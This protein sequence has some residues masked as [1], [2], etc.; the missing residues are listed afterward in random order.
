ML[1]LATL[2]RNVGEPASDSRYD[3]PKEL[4]ALGYTG[5][6]FYE[7][8]A[9]SGVPRPDVLTDAEL[10]RWVEQ[11]QQDLDQN[12]GAAVAA[13][14]DV[15]L[16]YDVLALAQELVQR[17]AAV[18]T[19]KGRPDTL[20]PASDR[21][22]SQ[23]MDGL[24]A[25]LA[26]WPQAAGVVLR[27]GDTDAR[28]LPYL[29]GNDLYA[30]HCPRCNAFG[31]ADRI[32]RVI[33]A[34]Y[35][36]VVEQAGKRLI[37]RAWNVR[38]GGMHD[39][40]ELTQRIVERLP[41]PPAS[42]DDDR[43]VL[44]FKFTQTDFWRYQPW[45]P[46]SLVCGDR[47]VIYE[48][49]C[50]REFEGKGGLPSWQAGLWRDGCPE[51]READGSVSGLAEAA[52]RMN[53]AGVMAWVR[54]G[55]WGGP[56]VSDESWIDA[57]VF[58]APRLADD[59]TVSPESLAEGWARQRL[60]LR[61]DNEVAAVCGVLE[62][63][64]D[65]V[66]R[67]F[68]VES[69]ARARPDA[70][71]PA[72]DWITDDLLDVEAAWRMVQGLPVDRLDA[73]VDEKRRAADLA[74]ATRHDFQVAVGERGGVCETLLNTL[75]YQES[76]AEA[77]RDLMAG[78]IAYRRLQ[79]DRKAS[80]TAQR[81]AADL[82]RRCLLQA[83]SHWNHH[84]QRHGNLRGTATPFRELGLWELTQQMMAEASDPA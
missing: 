40:P 67:A 9:M 79:A 45:N 34:A 23:C 42:P 58:A 13:G 57:N 55:G 71:H 65:L 16:S 4:A 8:A 77:L 5:R 48:L 38:P 75:V 11:Q 44:S 72:A 60:G 25:M 35:E 21:T 84:T 27:F 2:I 46:A 31:R 17:H 68:Y 29:T 83:Q 80:K 18:L 73:T 54:G 36:R 56:F 41:A 43:L 19:C 81:A 24:T 62:R 49:Q 26:R 70:W 50:Q 15:Y 59:P 3:D 20:C 12:I 82:V 30:P 6:V 53:F 22:I 61:E 28:R 1:K 37:V 32:V 76:F 14:L 10:R 64:A 52:G 39:S 51:M 63:S 47:P 33:T 69:Y 7:S 78:L 74:A 66:R